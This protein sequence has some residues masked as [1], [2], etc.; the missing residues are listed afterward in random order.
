MTNVVPVGRGVVVGHE[1]CYPLRIAYCTVRSPTTP[2]PPSGGAFNHKLCWSMAGGPATD[3]TFD[4]PGTYAGTPYGSFGCTS[5]GEHPL[6][7]PQSIHSATQRLN[8]PATYLITMYPKPAYS[9]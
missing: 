9:T 6:T 5:A 7:Q 2:L 8:R 3:G 4:Q 1:S